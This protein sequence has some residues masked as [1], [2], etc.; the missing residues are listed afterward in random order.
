MKAEGGL[1][2]NYPSQ[3][4]SVVGTVW[5]NKFKIHEKKKR[6]YGHVFATLIYMWFV[7]AYT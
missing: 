1:Y 5:R 6:V 2:I 4:Y 3:K 7:L